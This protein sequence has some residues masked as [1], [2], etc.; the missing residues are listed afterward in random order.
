[1]N[2]DSL[3]PVGDLFVR[4]RSEYGSPLHLTS[5]KHHAEVS[6][7]YSGIFALIR[8]AVLL[9]A[10]FLLVD[11]ALCQLQMLVAGGKSPITPA[12]LKVALMGAFAAA[13]L[14][15]G[16]LRNQSATKIALLFF[17]YLV[18]DTLYQYFGLGIPFTDILLSY[19]AYYALPLLGVIAISIPLK[20]SDRLLTRLLIILSLICGGLG[21]AQ[22]VTNSPIVST[23][24]SDGNFQVR[25]WSSLGH[26]RVFSLFGEPASCAVFFC[27][28][29]SL[30]V[31]MCRRKKNL[32]IAAPLLVLSLLISWA[33]GARTNIV[34]TA[35]GVITSWVI[36]F[37]AKRDRTKWLPFLWLAIGITVALYAYFQTGSGGLSTGVMTDATSFSERLA[38]WFRFLEMFRST[39]VLNLLFGYGMVQN[40]KVDPTGLGG[41][42]NLYLAVILHIGIVGLSLVMLLL[43]HLWQLVRT[44]AETRT[45]YL[46]TAVAATYSTVLLTG[47]FK[48]NF[49]GA[50][51]LIFAISKDRH[52]LK[53]A[54]DRMASESTTLERSNDRP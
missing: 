39:S 22:Y 17:A 30:T 47:M 37:T 33:S 35:C 29:G 32:I 2:G 8:F 7:T 20:I 3:V 23:Q 25:V 53:T 44:E 15:R 10:L 43:W 48:L 41:S 18:V 13:F 26:I 42:D 28:I 40:S 24:S 4:H 34:G 45:S 46:T 16:K 5:S 27:L 14:F 52:H 31:A 54:G 36:T 19:N 21:I 9:I 6:G 50:I 38:I 51:F 49:F 11:A 1:M 12:V